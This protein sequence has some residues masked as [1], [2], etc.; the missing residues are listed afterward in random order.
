MQSCFSNLYSDIL[1]FVV[2]YEVWLVRFDLLLEVM[3]GRIF[4]KF[5]IA[6]KAQL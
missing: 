6:P 2:F 3:S 1:K 5:D 4:A